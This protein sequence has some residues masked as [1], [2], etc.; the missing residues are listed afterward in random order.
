MTA[1]DRG[2]ILRLSGLVRAEALELCSGEGRAR[3]EEAT[4]GGDIP[5]GQSAG[6]GCRLSDSNTGIYGQLDCSVR[7]LWG[8]GHEWNH[9]AASVSRLPPWLNVQPAHCD[10]NETGHAA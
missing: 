6:V 7:S 9:T 8:Y 4:S 3:M 5:R 2:K 1:E 10:S